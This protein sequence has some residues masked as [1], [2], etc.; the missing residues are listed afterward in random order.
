MVANP[1]FSSS[2]SDDMYC[3]QQRW[4]QLFYQSCVSSNNICA[5]AMVANPYFSRSSR[6]IISIPL[7]R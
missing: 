6:D 5:E 4:Q 2:S 3:L 7:Q 1:Y